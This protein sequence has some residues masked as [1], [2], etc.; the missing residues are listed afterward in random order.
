METAVELGSTAKLA[1]DGTG[2]GAERAVMPHSGTPIHDDVRGP[3]CLVAVGCPRFSW[4]PKADRAERSQRP[5]RRADPK[6]PTP[7]E[8]RG[9]RAE[10]TQGH[11]PER[12]QG[13]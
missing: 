5:R 2:G 12:T 8:L 4:Q 1:A 11:R 13:T 6:A 10:R 3:G 7:N 9:S